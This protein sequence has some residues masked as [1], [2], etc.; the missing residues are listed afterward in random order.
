MK[1]VVLGASGMVG[2]YLSKSLRQNGHTVIE[3]SRSSAEFKLDLQRLPEEAQLMEK[4][5][6]VDCVCNCIG[7][8]PGFDAEK[9][10]LVH[11][12]AMKKVLDAARK[13]N[14]KK[15][16]QVSALSN[17]VGA[18]LEIPYLASKYRLDKELLENHQPHQTVA[19]IR[20]SLIYAPIGLST[21]GFLRMARLP[22]LALP[23]KG[24]MIIQPIHV[25]D[26][27]G[28][29]NELLTQEHE[30][31]VYEIGGTTMSLA[32]YINYLSP[33]PKRK[34][35]GV[36]DLISRIGMFFMHYIEPAIGG[37]NAY[38][39]LLAGSNTSQNQFE[40]ILKRKAIEPQDF[41]QTDLR[42]SS[43]SEKEE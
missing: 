29:I 43:I 5:I 20:P 28:F 35:F 30:S 15:I 42:F 7:I 14:I 27:C 1:I 31:Q 17:A 22:W 19:I 40:V 39:L 13:A 36:P 26:L 16:I 11:F 38:R 2:R 23:N 18:D 9:Q 6:G 12:H 33:N 8:A 3:A 34:T 21:I 41:H 37:V 32:S 24:N 10:F 4:F 25:L